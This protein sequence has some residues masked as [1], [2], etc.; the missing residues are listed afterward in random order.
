MGELPSHSSGVGEPSPLSLKQ[1]KFTL[2]STWMSYGEKWPSQV[3]AAADQNF[4][5]TQISADYF[6][7]YLFS[8][9]IF[10]CQISSTIRWVIITSP[11]FC[12]HS[13]GFFKASYTSY[14]CKIKNNLAYTEE[15]NSNEMDRI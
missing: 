14:K 3:V 15:I 9:S 1:G 6:D 12:L 2:P 5:P 11:V 4:Q 8:Q 10:P 7:P 13:L